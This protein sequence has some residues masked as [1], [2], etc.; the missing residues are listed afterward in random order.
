MDPNARPV[1][2][3]GKPGSSRRSGVAAKRSSL[4]R[5]RLHRFIAHCGLSSRRRAELLI[6]MGRV[7]VNGRR[8]EN[9]GQIVNPARD[10]VA[11]N[12]EEIR[13]PEPLTIAFHKP[14]DVITSTHDTHER[15]TVMDL[16]PQSVQRRGVLPVGRLDRDTEGLL[17]LTNDGEL[18]HK[19]AHPSHEIEKEYEALVRGHPSR[20][21]LDRLRRGVVI[22]GV[23]TAPAHV[24]GIEREGARTRV[25]LVI[26]EGKKR[27]VRRMFETV[28]HEVV[29][30]KR[31]RVGGLQL[32][33]LAVGT[34]RPLS[35]AETASL[36]S[37][38]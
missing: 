32:G 4:P 28:N 5:M 30:L 20:S 9:K 37:G 10:R 38:S 13:P 23:K 18:S 19:I 29:E 27:Q 3:S 15:L 36:L 21:A 31:L 17:V 6:A 11:V 2:A 7:E 33:A 12:G 26:H 8:V 24:F 1:E 14:K 35:D 25:R 34:W 22:E 16:L